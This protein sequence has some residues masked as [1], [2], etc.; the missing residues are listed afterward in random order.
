MTQSQKRSFNLAALFTLIAVFVHGYLAKQHYALKFGGATESICNINATFNC[1]AVAASGW[2]AFLGVPMAI[3]GATANV[4]LLILLLIARYG[5]SDHPERSGRYA[6]WLATLVAAASIVMGGISLT[7]MNAYCVF[8]ML[9]YVLSFL[10]LFFAWRGAGGFGPLV[11]DLKA[12]FGENK[13][14]GIL[15][16]AIPL[17]AIFVH[18]S[19]LNTM[20]FSRIAAEA[21]DRV[22]Q[23]KV[24]PEM[25]FDETKGLIRGP[26]TGARLT[27]V[28][29]ADYLCPHCKHAAPVLATFA[30]VH[31][32]VKIVFKPFPLDGVCNPEPQMPKG[33]GVRCRIAGFVQCAEKLNQ[34]GWDAQHH[35][36]ENQESF[37]EG[38]AADDVF[39]D[40]CAKAGVDCAPLVA[41]ADSS[42]TRD[43][44]KA[45]A[46]EGLNAKIRG[47][48]TIFANKRL[49]TG[50][51]YM[52]I[53]EEAHKQAP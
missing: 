39:K 44:I 30:G 33:D 5:L 4:I 50:G 47:T 40:Y 16:V 48:P 3:W 27:V 26:A 53:L 2:S 14:T 42:E 46:Q 34:K 20:G 29:F 13:A 21:A 19:A 43:E 36:F 1:D 9:A 24:N 31:S 11:A 52:P 6:L 10:G 41:C 15:F 12:L 28:E 8:C 23:W 37:F 7:L 51:Q 18:K 32:D 17:V 45:L 38:K 25:T 22:A 35:M 49:L